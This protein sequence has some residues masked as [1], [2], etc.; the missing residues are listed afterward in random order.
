[1]SDKRM[2][3]DKSEAPVPRSLST[4]IAATDAL[5][6]AL[7]RR[8]TDEVAGR[9][10]DLDNAWTKAQVDNLSI[11]SRQGDALNCQRYATALNAANEVVDA[12]CALLGPR[13]QR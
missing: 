4:L 11:Y 13:H 1:M 6:Q 7:S 3:E 5:R 10:K 2:Y 12:A 8:Q 9:L